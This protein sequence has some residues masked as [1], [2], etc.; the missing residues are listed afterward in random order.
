MNKFQNKY[1][2]PSARATWWNY[3]NHGL[4]FIADCKS[5]P[6]TKFK[7]ITPK[8]GKNKEYEIKTHHLRVYLFHE[9]NT[10]RVIVC[11][12]KKGSQNS[13][14]KHFRKIK[15]EYFKQKP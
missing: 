12:G 5:L 8:N 15:K 9:K 10:G 6:Q 3:A 4:Y 13:D 14:I 1:R 11:G 7:D 2:I